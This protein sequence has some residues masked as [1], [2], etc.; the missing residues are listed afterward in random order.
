MACRNTVEPSSKLKAMFYS[1]F[2]TNATRHG[3][4]YEN[5]VLQLSF[6]DWQCWIAS[7]QRLSIFGASL[8]GIGVNIHSGQK[9]GVEIKCPFSK[10]NMTMEQAMVVGPTILN[11]NAKKR[12]FLK[13]QIYKIHY[14]A[15]HSVQLP[16]CTETFLR[17]TETLFLNN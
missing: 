12:I 6:Q 11:A 14:L 2:H 13:P 16:P 9:W 8:D 10:Y 7:L 3:K 15:I 17:L 4:Q 1:S 5:H